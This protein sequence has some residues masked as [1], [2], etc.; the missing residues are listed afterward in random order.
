MHAVPT[1]GILVTVD[2]LLYYNEFE[3]RP[4]FKGEV[5][6]LVSE[7]HILTASSAIYNSLTI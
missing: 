7:L 6:H 3:L 2:R 4:K 5:S 1:T